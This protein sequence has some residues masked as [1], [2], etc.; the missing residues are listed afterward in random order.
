MHAQFCGL[1]SV[2]V[3]DLR[4][5]LWKLLLHLGMCLKWS[6]IFFNIPF[7]RVSFFFSRLCMSDW[8][9]SIPVET[10]GRRWQA[11]SIQVTCALDKF[12]SFTSQKCR[13]KATQVEK[14]MRLRTAAVCIL[15][16][17]DGSRGIDTADVR[18]FSTASQ[19]HARK[20]KIEVTK[21]A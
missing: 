21:I 3:Y 5:S 2:N 13:H 17:S 15:H 16:C 14:K 18:P 8:S 11:N 20:L 1:A 6:S 12:T 19:T 4:W 10:Y 9:V 7:F